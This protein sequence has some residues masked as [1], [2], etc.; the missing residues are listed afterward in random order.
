MSFKNVNNSVIKIVKEDFIC[1]HEE[2]DI[3]IISQMKS[4]NKGKVMVKCDTDILL[5]FLDFRI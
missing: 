2:F 1:N 4:E 3:R 5:S